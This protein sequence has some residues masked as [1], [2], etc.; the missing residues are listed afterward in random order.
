M[1]DFR[2]RMDFLCPDAV[3]WY[4]EWAKK[5]IANQSTINKPKTD[6]RSVQKLL[7]LV[8]WSTKT[9]RWWLSGLRDFRCRMDFL[10]PDAVQWYREWAKK[11]IANQSTINKPK[12]DLRSVQ[13]LPSLAVWS[14]KTSRLLRAGLG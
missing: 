7:S 11:F 2:C 14:T 10:C 4:R 6:L 3:Q 9:S 1:R 8:V 12:T 13:K 5:F